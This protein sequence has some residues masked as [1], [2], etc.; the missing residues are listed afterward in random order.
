MLRDFADGYFGPAGGKFL[1]YR[2]L[3]LESMQRSKPF[4]AMYPPG[5]GAYVHL[6]LDTVLQAQRLFDE[7]AEYLG[8]AEILLARWRHARLSL[9]R[10]ALNLER[11]LMRHV[12]RAGRSELSTRP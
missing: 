3:L 10:A 7:G 1:E 4:I 5:A 6:D 9:D 8:S 11:P 12:M 2:N